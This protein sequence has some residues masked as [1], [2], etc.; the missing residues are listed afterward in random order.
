MVSKSTYL[1]GPFRLGQE[2]RRGDEMIEL[3]PK[4]F[5]VLRILVSNAGDLVTKDDLWENVWPRV[6]VS[7]AALTVC[8]ADVRKALGDDARNARFIAT[9]PKRG[10][11]FIAPVTEEQ[12]SSD[13]T[14]ADGFPSLRVNGHLLG[15]A[16]ELDVLNQ[17]FNRAVQ[18]E[19][20]ICFVTGEVGIGKTTLLNHFL[21]GLNNAPQ[22]VIAYG[23]CIEQYGTSEPYLPIFDALGQLCARPENTE[24]ISVLCTYAPLWVTQMPGLVADATIESIQ[25]HNLNA[26][27]VRMLRELTNALEEIGKLRPMILCLEDIHWADTATLD[28]LAFIASH[29]KGSKL[30]VIATAR[31]G[32]GVARREAKSLIDQLSI[33]N[34]CRTLT[35]ASLSVDDVRRYIFDELVALDDDILPVAEER[36]DAAK[37]DIARTL[38]T[39]TDGNPLFFTN[40][41]RH[42]IDRG[43]VNRSAFLGDEDGRLVQPESYGTPKNLRELI[44]QQVSHLPQSQQDAITAGCIVGRSFSVAAATAALTMP[45][46]D[47]EAVY[48]EVANTTDI[49]ESRGLDEWPNGTVATRYEFK[50]SLYAEV[51]YESLA[52]GRLA[53]LHRAIAATIA[54]AYGSNMDD[55]A[56]ELAVH[57]ERGS[58]LPKAAECCLIA[59]RNALRSAGYTEAVTRFRH[60]IE[61]LGKTERA[62]RED[63][64]NIE[65]E[66][67]LSLGSTLIA[68]SG[69]ATPDIEDCYSRAGALARRVGDQPKEFAAL[70]GLRSVAL[71]K[72]EILKADSFGR[73]L[74]EIAEGVEG[75][76]LRLEAHLAIANT[77]FQLGKLTSAHRNLSAALEIY[78]PKVHGRHVEIYGLEPGV[79]CCSMVALVLELSGSAA[80]AKIASTRALTL[81]ENSKHEFSLATAANFA[82]WLSQ[83]REQPKETAE[84][85]RRA[86]EIAAKQGFPTAQALG[87]IRHGWALVAIGENISEGI[88]EIEDGIAA[89]RELG[90]ILG[91]PHFLSLLADAKKRLG[92]THEALNAIDEAFRLINATD[93]RWLE[94]T[95]YRQLA[96]L[97]LTLD[98]D[99]DDVIFDLKRGISIAD[100]QGAVLLEQQCHDVMTLIGPSP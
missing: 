83:V 7:D 63:I 51:L 81:A 4:A 76:G 26:T 92:S 13:L 55:V 2:L 69:S 99:R 97:K 36:F 6:I 72:G 77:S 37:T 84:H 38:H 1:F 10:Y 85:S 88:Q 45:A 91:R 19:R 93:E 40:M 15:R 14:F 89:W 11:R 74:L 43:A 22:I 32:E 17:C 57:Y 64:E 25:Q 18:G 75:E 30:L 41:F 35:L 50:H 96:E 56:A 86:M 62:R 65:A 29:R 16:H 58:E 27:P 8:V 5:D 60:G 79:F 68:S 82:A 59:G 61:L 21:S 47:A 66:L 12:N 100:T 98:N 95:L 46:G 90:N 33:K 23:Q 67:R 34:Q 39:R 28:W 24:L 52:A 70:F 42:W 78:D 20:Q 71:A 49:I 73:E 87:Q 54:G 53:M 80:E 48:A 9:V 31:S 3:T 44:L 94:S